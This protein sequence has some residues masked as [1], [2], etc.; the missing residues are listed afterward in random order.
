MAACQFNIRTLLSPTPPP[1]GVWHYVG[2]A[3]E[4]E[5]GPFTDTPA[6]PIV[7]AVADTD[8]PWGD[9]FIIFYKGKT[10]GYYKF[11]YAYTGGEDTVIVDL[12]DGGQCAGASGTITVSI[13]DNTPVDL[14]GYLDSAACPTHTTGGRWVDLDSV[15]GT[16]FNTTT[17][18]L[19]PDELPG[20][21]EY[22]FLYSLLPD[23]FDAQTC[24]CES[25]EATITVTAA[26]SVSAYINVADADCDFVATFEN[27]DDATDSEVTITVDADDEKPKM[28]YRLIVES[29][30]GEL[31]NAVRVVPSGNVGLFLTNDVGDPFQS[32]GYFRN[33]RL[34]STAGVDITVPLAPLG[35]DQATY[36]GVGGT[37]NATQL[38]FNPASPSVFCSAIQTA[39]LNYL[40]TLGYTNGTDFR[41]FGVTID[42]TVAP[43]LIGKII[44]ISFG[45]KH[46]PTGTWIGLRQ[47]DGRIQYIEAPGGVLTTVTAP[48][49]FGSG[50]SNT[51]VYT[52]APCPTGSDKIEF[53]VARTTSLANETTLD[54]NSIPLPVSTASIVPT[55]TM[56]M[57]C[58]G[59]TLTAEAVN[60]AGSLTYLWSTGETT[61]SVVV[62]N[63]TFTVVVS[64]SS[65]S[66]DL[67]VTVT[68]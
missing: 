26:M 62:Q 22:R 41:L 61:Q 3:E 21:G 68:V 43:S 64:C 17:G 53:T 48:T 25:L 5:A 15:G 57:S 45:S 50:A 29:C 65:P 14:N 35:T 13:M 63:G 1:G 66:D 2:Y 11:T 59:K 20:P 58:A 54:Y 10:P 60:C 38:T 4:S 37:T 46:S 28:S 16:A 9:D 49:R 31:V 51:E 23:G 52:H 47:S 27:P 12:E 24:D 32:G 56:S 18:V 40:G 19:T 33:I 34:R 6:N 42:T 36:S 55:G 44:K 8:L 39:I 67:E 30:E 7:N